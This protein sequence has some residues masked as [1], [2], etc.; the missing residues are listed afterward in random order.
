M[1]RTGSLYNRVVVVGEELLERVAEIFASLRDVDGALH[2]W[3]ELVRELAGTRFGA[4]YLREPE[5]GA[6]RRWLETPET[7]DLSIPFAMVD[8]IFADADHR[9]LELRDTGFVG[10]RAIQSALDARMFGAIGFAMRHERAIVG[11]LGLGFPERPSIPEP[12]LRTLATVAR[13]P[14]A[15][16][17]HARLEEVAA[18]RARTTEELRLFGERALSAPDLPTLHKLILETTVALTGSDQASITRVEGNLVRMVAGVG[19]DEPLVGTTAPAAMMQEALSPLEPYVVR[20]TDAADGTKLLVKLAR[21]TAAR[22]FMALPL[23]HQ[24]RLFGHLFAGAAQPFRYH[25]DEVEAMRILASMSAAVLEQRSAQADAETTARRLAQTIEHLPLLVEVF[26]GQGALVRSNGAARALRAR[27]GVTS[28]SAA[29]LFP[30]LQARELDGRAIEASQLPSAAALRGE[31]PVPH[32]IELTTPSPEGSGRLATLLVAAA[33]VLAPD[34]RVETV[35]VGC[36]DVSRLHDLARAKDRFLRVAAHELRTPIT[37][38]YASL[39]LYDHAPEMFDDPVQRAPLFARLRR[40]SVRLVKLVQQLLDSVQANAAELPLQR[41]DVDL[42]ALAKD[43]V[44]TSMP[45]SGPRAVVVSDGPVV[46]RW[47]ALRVE[48]VLTNLLSNAARYSP[49]D[50]EVLVRV[51]SDGDSAMLS[52]RDRG[53]GIPQRDLDQLFTPFFRGANA[54]AH[55][56]AGLGLG[57]HIAQEIVRRH[58]GRIS[59]ESKESEGTTFT[60]QL[61]LDAPILRRSGDL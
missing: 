28:G 39:Q 6:Y 27:L 59:V 48:Q 61:P 45:S 31:T 42:V 8:S 26:D 36:Q 50:G 25:D 54:H 38:L 52:V 5:R 21:K 47:D 60:V 40:Q 13:F 41:S 29:A 37:A 16:I 7:P 30:G 1:L 11:V 35:V 23:R 55:H 49:A 3:L 14:A 17:H 18:R 4:I 9:V 33:P 19:K 58:G 53:I 22:S 2:Q 46:G 51:R 20:D 34:G 24:S 57:L 44:E 32:E 43:V 12:L 56:A 10:E 15:A